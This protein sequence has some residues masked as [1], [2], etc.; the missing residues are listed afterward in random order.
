M[1]LIIYNKDNNVVQGITAF[2]N[3]EELLTHLPEVVGELV[4]DIPITTEMNIEQANLFLAYSGSSIRLGTTS[5]KIDIESFSRGVVLESNI[6]VV[7]F[8]PQDSLLDYEEVISSAIEDEVARRL[9]LITS[10]GISSN[11]VLLNSLRILMDHGQL[12]YYVV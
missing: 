11:Q 12:K 9:F 8:L 6:G 1:K 7:V 10:K 3:E 4:F 2:N 5:T